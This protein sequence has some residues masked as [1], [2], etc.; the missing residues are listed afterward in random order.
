MKPRLRSPRSRYVEAPALK[1]AARALMMAV[2]YRVWK[3]KLKRAG[4]GKFDDRIIVEIASGAGFLLRWLRRS[5]PRSLI[6]GSD[7][8]GLSVRF[9]AGAAPQAR[10]LRAD[11]HELPFRSGAAD[12][13]FIIQAI[14]HLADPD[15]F[16]NEAGRILKDGGLLVV[17]T[18]NPRGTAA[19]L[20]GKRWIGCVPSHVSLRAPEEWR[21]A[22]E[23]A[24]FR[25]RAGGTT[26]LTS[27]PL[28]K[29]FPF[30]LVSW[31]P[32]AL[33]GFFPWRHGDSAVFLFQ[34]AAEARNAR[35]R[36]V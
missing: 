9:A 27:V 22:G 18:P 29:V 6:V 11:A 26:G 21:E 12:A 2:S 10:C 4:F 1:R 36:S 3:R 14:E 13:V 23:R 17:A 15:R 31:I 30:A 5:Y 34:N 20:M 25:V 16:L 33:F 7:V 8:D 19:R 32:M 28:L 24:G 35:P